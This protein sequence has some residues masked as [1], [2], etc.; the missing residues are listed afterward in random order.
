MNKLHEML[1]KHEGLKLKVYKCSAGKATI[2]VGR[3][4]EDL[5]ISKEEAMILLENDVLRCFNELNGFDWFNS[6][7]A[8]RQDA[9]INMVFNLGLTRFLTFKKFIAAITIKQFEQASEEM[10]DSLWA[11]Q[12]GSRAFELSQ[13]VRTGQYQF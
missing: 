1:I 7:D 12:V 13:M 6:L 2:G 11:Q 8:V 10:L 9:I 3:N 4:I 5:G